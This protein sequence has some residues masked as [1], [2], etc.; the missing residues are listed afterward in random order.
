MADVSRVFICNSGSEANEAALKFCRKHGRVTDPAGSKFEFLSFRNS[1][2]GRTFGSLS[3]TPNEKYQAPFSPMI[4]G[5]QYGKLND[6]ASLDLITPRTC[7]V[8][9][10]PIQ[11]EGGIHE[12]SPTFLSALR[13]RCNEAGALLVYD[14][15]QCGLS[16]TGKFWAHCTLP[17]SVHPDILTTAKALGNGF[18]VGATLVTEAVAN[19]IVPGDHGTTFGGNPLAAR[20]AHHVVTRLANPDLQADVRHR[21]HHFRLRLKSF[22][23]KFPLLITEIRGR[24]L[25]L[26]VQMSHGAAEVVS[27]AR[28]RGLLIITAGKETLRLVPPLTIKKHEVEEG[29]DILEKAINVVVN[30]D[31]ISKTE[32]QQEMG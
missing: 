12:A 20:V 28:E 7:G 3:A 26:G 32:G 14:E 23:E 22:Q 21:E 2:H 4:P 10:E 8:I 27:A 24:G 1:F 17:P 31:H 5:F 9:V 29:L 19:V 16:R 6:L 30:E 15:I 18:P 25:I 13:K 11:G